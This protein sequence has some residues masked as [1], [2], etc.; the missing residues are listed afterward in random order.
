MYYLQW[1]TSDPYEE[2]AA[3]DLF[4][5]FHY[6]PPETLTTSQFDNVYQYVAD[7]ET[8]DLEELYA[9]WNRGSGRESSTFLELRYCDRC[10]SYINGRE[11]GITHAA[12]NHGYDGLTESREPD[13]IHGER[14]MSVGDIVERN[15]QYYACAPI[16]W[17]EL[18][19]YDR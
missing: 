15:N 2:T 12:Q 13:Y 9:E 11:E 17:Q 4:H 10:D 19:Q 3:S 18:E 16:G 8:D 5:E 1:H 6:D 14:S 7:V